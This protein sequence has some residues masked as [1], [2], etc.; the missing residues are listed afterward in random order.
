[1]NFLTFINGVRTFVSKV[2]FVDFANGAFR[3]RIQSKVL[4]ANQLL[5]APNKTGTIA[6]AEETQPLTNNLSAIAPISTNGVY[7]KTGTAT[8]DTLPVGTTGINLLAANTAATAQGTI[9]LDKWLNMSGAVIS[10]PLALVALTAREG[11]TA[12]SLWK[13]LTFESYTGLSTIKSQYPGA[14]GK[15]L[16]FKLIL[17]G[18]NSMIPD[19]VGYEAQTWWDTSQNGKLG[20][21]QYIIGYDWGAGAGNIIFDTPQRYAE[22]WGAGTN[23]SSLAIVPITIPDPETLGQTKYWSIHIRGLKK[24]PAAAGAAQFSIYNA[25]LIGVIP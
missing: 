24:Y 3:S 12:D 19:D 22:Y 1:M 13:R 20:K 23:G 16:D 21:M 10:I 2:D 8:A 25:F 15:S 18:T 5:E 6:I 14:S 11:L 7:R 17:F 9:G 4:T